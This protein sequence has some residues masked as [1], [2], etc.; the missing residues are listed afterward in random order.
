M[1]EVR[2]VL[3]S[4]GISIGGTGT[5][6]HVFHLFLPHLSGSIASIHVQHAGIGL[7]GHILLDATAKEGLHVAVF[8]FSGGDALTR[9]GAD[10]VVTVHILRGCFGAIR[11]EFYHGN[12]GIRGNGGGPCARDPTRR[13]GWLIG[14]VAKRRSVGTIAGF[15]RVGVS[16]RRL[17]HHI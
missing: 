12:I 4:V 8:V 6:K 7:G 11:A 10:H 13:I 2:I 1:K 17:I 9:E 16:I 3:H 15:G 5:L 14:S